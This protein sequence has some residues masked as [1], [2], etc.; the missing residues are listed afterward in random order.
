ELYEEHLELEKEVEK[1]ERYAAYSSSAALRHKQLK[2][3]KLRGMDAIMSI[4]HEH[5]VSC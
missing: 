5:R 1:L 3:E 4:L 2:K